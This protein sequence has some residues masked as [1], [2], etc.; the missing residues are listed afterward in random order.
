MEIIKGLPIP[1]EKVKFPFEQMEVGDCFRIDDES[2]FSRCR[3]YANQFKVF[4]FKTRT[5]DGV[6]HVW[7]TA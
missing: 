3:A 1:K 4:K 5:I 7:R 2:D 6:L